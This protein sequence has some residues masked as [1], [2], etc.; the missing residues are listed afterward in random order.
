MSGTIKQPMKK[1]NNAQTIKGKTVYAFG[2]ES[3]IIRLKNEVMCY[4]RQNAVDVK[5]C[6]I[7]GFG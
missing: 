3:V 5:G 2:N 6:S 1:N 4:G 7:S